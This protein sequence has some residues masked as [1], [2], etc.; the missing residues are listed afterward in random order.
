LNPELKLKDRYQSLL[1]EERK[2]AWKKELDQVM[3]EAAEGEK[4]S[5]LTLLFDRDPVRRTKETGELLN[6]WKKEYRMML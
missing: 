4:M 1:T 3:A 2:T 5:E 6:R